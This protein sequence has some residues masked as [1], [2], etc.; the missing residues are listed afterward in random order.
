MPDILLPDGNVALFDWSFED[1]VEAD[2]WW[3]WRN[4][5]F[6]RRLMVTSEVYPQRNHSKIL[7]HRRIAERLVCDR[8]EVEKF[9][10]KE[11]YFTVFAKDQSFL[12]CTKENLHVRVRPLLPRPYNQMESENILQWLERGGGVTRR[13]RTW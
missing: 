1:I 4:P 3:T 11:L 8:L 2:T 7:L 12:N 5:G 13:H 6:R 10:S 9:P